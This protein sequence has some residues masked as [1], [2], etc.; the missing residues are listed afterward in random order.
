[1][2][3][4]VCQ[5]GKVNTS[6]C[7]PRGMFLYYSLYI[8]WIILASLSLVSTGCDDSAQLEQR[9]S[10]EHR[11]SI[12]NIMQL[13]SETVNH[14]KPFETSYLLLFVLL[15]S[16]TLSSHL[17]RRRPS[18]QLLPTPR[19]FSTLQRDRKRWEP[20]GSWAFSNGGPGRFMQI[21]HQLQ[22][23]IILLTGWGRQGRRLSL[24]SVTHQLFRIF[25]LP[26]K[27]IFV[28]HI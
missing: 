5:L 7:I 24:H 26:A 2:K 23:F 15:E 8:I 19:C 11:H 18:F 3:S 27:S 12:F 22:W 21:R 6:I 20:K 16:Y 25:A 13:Y 9:L 14:L 28:H 10:Q 1:M 17:C 4:S